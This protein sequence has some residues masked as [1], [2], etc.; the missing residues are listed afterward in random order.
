MITGK[1]G[2]MLILGLT[3]ENLQR[4]PK[5]PIYFKMKERIQVDDFAPE[6]VLICY[7]DTMEDLEKVLV[8]NNL[9]PDKRTKLN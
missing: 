3:K 1:K 7:G 8:K 6:D 4:L 2:K 5:E 9:M